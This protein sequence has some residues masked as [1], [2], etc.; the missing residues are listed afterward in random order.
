MTLTKM[1]SPKALIVTTVRLLAILLVVGALTA[2][3]PADAETIRRT[4]AKAATKKLVTKP[5]TQNAAKGSIKATRTNPALRQQLRRLDMQALSRIESR[6]G[7]HINPSRMAQA[8][9]NPTTFL[10]HPGYQRQLQRS[11]PNMPAKQRPS[12]VGNYVG[13]KTYVDRNQVLVPRITAH[14]R[15]HSLA[16]PRFRMRTGGRLDEGMTEFFA[17]RTYSDLHIRNMPAAYPQQRKV[18]EMMAARV[19]D[20]SLARAYFGGNVTHLQKQLDGQIG[21]GSFRSIVRAVEMGRHDEAV[22]ILRYSR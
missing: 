1:C 7:A 21:R 19:G 10:S 18:V 14:E 4:V 12:V 22:R 8:K 6:Y 2:P 16:D 20:Q 9:A 5:A 15:I 17:S 13:G 11:Y 3:Q